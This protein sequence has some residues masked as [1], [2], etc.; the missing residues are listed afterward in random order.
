MYTVRTPRQSLSNKSLIFPHV[1][2][3]GRNLAGCFLVVEAKPLSTYK[4][5]VAVG[6]EVEVQNVGRIHKL[7][8][9]GNSCWAASIAS[10][11]SSG[12]SC[13]YVKYQ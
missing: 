11:D 4:A 1:L 10:H 6:A 9:G 13:L 8:D 7:V 2:S 5:V 3:P 12:F